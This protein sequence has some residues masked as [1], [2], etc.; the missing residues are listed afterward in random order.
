M[1]IPD[2][3]NRDIVIHVNG[4]LVPR[5]DAKVSVF[6]SVVQGGDA[7]WE[8]LRVYR[9]RIAAL[10]EKLGKAKRPAVLIEIAERHIGQAQIDPAA[11]TEVAIFCTETGFEVIDAD[12]G[13]KKRAEIVITGE[14]FSEFAA[15][16][17][18]LVWVKARLEVKAVNRDTGRVVAIDRQTTVAVDL[19]E[20]IAGKTALQQ[21]A[22]A[23]CE[24]LV[25]K[26]VTPKK[27]GRDKKKKDE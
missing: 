26:L 2:P 24:R 12:E 20:Q 15:R 4:K 25:P 3:R 5:D 1:N 17:S 10:N 21:A 22:A 6:D 9:G 19:T 16:H 13:N 14:G 7:V 11:E 8:G 23:I 27:K 18:D